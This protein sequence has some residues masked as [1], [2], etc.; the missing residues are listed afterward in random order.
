MQNQQATI[1]FNTRGA[2]FRTLDDT[3]NPHE[4]VRLLRETADAI[5]AGHTN[6][7][8]IDD[9]GNTVGAFKIA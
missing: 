9:N 8:I 5:Q 6:G 7:P 1:T 2:I 3:L 4:V